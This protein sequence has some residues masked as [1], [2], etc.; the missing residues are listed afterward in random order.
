MGHRSRQ[1]RSHFA[2][3]AADIENAFLAAQLEFRD[4]FARPGLLDG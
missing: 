1:F 2:V 4:E 3:A